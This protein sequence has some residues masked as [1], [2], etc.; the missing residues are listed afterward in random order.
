LKQLVLSPR[1][2]AHLVAA[3]AVELSLAAAHTSQVDTPLLGRK[4]RTRPKFLVVNAVPM[5]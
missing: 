1:D 3:A 2:E 4:V 5:I